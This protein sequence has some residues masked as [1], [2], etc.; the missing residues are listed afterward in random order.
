MTISSTTVKN[1]YSGNGTLDTFNYTFKVFADADIQ[2]IIRDASAT[3]TVKTLTTHYTVTGAGSASG[4]TIVFTAGNIPSA[5]ETVVIR[6]ASPQ[7]QAIDYIANDP[8]PAESHEEGLDRS[9]MAVQ[10]LQEEVDRSIKLSR[11]N[12]MNSTEFAI[13]DTDRAGKVLGFD[14]GGE[15]TVAQE[16]GTF[17]GNWS[18][19]T[20]FAVRD[21]IKDTSNGNIYLCKTAHTSTG[22]QP[23]S[24]NTDVAKW[25]LLVDATAATTSATNAANSATAAATSETNAATSETNAST[26]ETNAATSAT[27]AAN[28]FDSF[29]D[30]FLGTKASDPTLD[31]DGNALVEGAMYYNSTDND[32][33]FYNGSTWDAP[34]T[35]AETSATNSANSATA[36]ATS[37]TNSANSA[38]ASATSATNAATSETNAETAE[39]NAE[40]AETNAA[41]SASAASTSASNAS[42]SESNAASS[43]STASTQASNAATSATNA[44]TSETN[45]A[46]SATSASA[47]ASTAT[48]KA[49]EASTSASNASTSASN[50]ASSAT[51]A[52]NAQTSVENIFDNFDDRFLGT[53][54]SDPTVDNDGNALSVGAVYY[55]SVA[56]EI[57]FY[58]GSSWDAPS[59][60]AATSATNASNSASAASTSATNA[61][62]SATNAAT[63]ATNAASSATDAQTA[64][65]AAETAQTAAETSE[66]NAATSESNASTFAS[67]ATTQASNA[68]TSATNAS[69]SATAAANSATAASNSE[70]AAASSETNA[71]SSETNA[72]SSASTASTQA[73]NASTSASNAASSAT[74]ATNSASTATTKASEASTSATNAANSAS[75]ASTQATNASNSAS[76]ASTSESNAS[77]SA[78]SALS[79]KNAA[80]TALDTFDDRFLGAKSSDPST[81]NDG[82]TLIDGALYFDSTNNLLKVYDLGNTQWN[83]TIPTSSDQTKINTVSGIASDVTDVAN[84]AADVTTTANNVSGINSFAERYRVASSDPTTSLD[85]GDLAFNTSGSVLK[86]YDGSSWQGIT[87]GG[88]TDVVQDSTPQLGGNLDTQSFTVDGRDVSTDGTK[89]DGIESGATADQ[90]DAE[91]KTAYENNS[92][93]NAYTDSEKTKLS[94]IETSATADQTASEI[95]TAVKTVDG[96]SSGLDADLLD[97][98]HGSYY[99]QY[100]DTAVSNLVA[101]AP[102]AL[103][104]LN[105]LAA[106]L[107]DDANFATTTA[108][109]L[110]EKL[111]KSGG[112]MTGTLAMGSN[113]ITTSSTVDGRD[114][115]ADGTKL[116]TIETNATADQTDAEIKTAYENNSNTNAFTDALQ[117]KL[118]SASTLTG[119]E[120]LTNKTLTSPKINENVAVT[121]TATELNKLDALSRGSIIYG[122]AS[123]ATAIL[124]KGSAGT[125]L[126]SDG[127]DISWSTVYAG[128]VWQSVQTTGFT[129]SAG[130]AYPCNTTSSG[131]TVTLPATPSA[132]D[133]VQLVDY[134]GTFDTNRL[135]IDGNGEDIEGTALNFQLTGE[136]EGVILTYID[137]TQGWIATSGINEGTDALSPESYSADFLVI[138]GGGAGGYT[139]DIGGGAGAGGYRNSYSSETSGGGGSSEASL[140]FVPDT[141]YTVTVGAGGT[142]GNGG[143]SVISGTGITTITSLGGGV[144]GTV[145]GVSGG[146]GS[147]AS[148]NNS[149]TGSGAGTSNQGFN[150]GF[151]SGGN[152]GYSSSGGGGAGAVGQ[153]A[154]GSGVSAIG[155]NGGNGVAS[156][157]TGSSIT[158]GGGGGGGDWSGGNYG[159]GG[160]GGG[161]TGGG[162]GAE[163]AVSGTA[164]TGGG[165]GGASSGTAVRASGGS[166]V[167]I[168]RM[169]TANYSGTVTGAE[170][171]I[172]DGTD[173]I[174]V[175]NGDGSYTG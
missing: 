75:T 81:D 159:A 104:T 45:A 100:A 36:S 125:V 136:R 65:T 77:S 3:E 10:Q 90:S 53:K 35:D 64:Q 112:T 128:I 73:S 161:G 60:S 173:T 98:Q 144:G 9:M 13:G 141:V 109:S 142:S 32:I 95:L 166:G 169:P 106:A 124:T 107:G 138:A 130:N 135:T 139:G 21:I 34:A 39:T 83:R 6:R 172:V 131:F 80:E 117:T 114:V 92:N 118:N 84:I 140:T 61:A 22:S 99:T 119:T 156:S 145:N 57:K 38:T 134:A 126:T 129:A 147:G 122:N 165:G 148:G 1:S 121:S 2:V 88:I 50:A 72:A 110:G 40:T 76:A 31:N 154:S 94:N 127:T 67:T 133:Q 16:L 42:T 152:G 7:T 66:T 158:R 62:T 174:L 105:E 93:T 116:D 28:S 113:P 56:N 162:T 175:F 74:S 102:A 41:S 29:D 97:G 5:T 79:Y 149:V 63:Q 30:R 82:D 68:S 58:N 55:N 87:A 123:A 160:S 4:G 43:A 23:I 151:Q 170:T 48:T 157:I 96:A 49:S 59:T 120:T 103:D 17:K 143:N 71:A 8:F 46:S 163:N 85:A 168:L 91:I 171:P 69:N 37:A 155:G 33:R 12:T 108:T 18:A 146:S 54:T 78:S 27:N 11:T 26:S 44:A 167:V 86:Y 24:S 20:T 15:L 89:L 132:G 51:A 25:D 153:A 101:S 150:G 19:S 47:S 52:S 115:S 137:S 164:N 70:T 111:P 14:A